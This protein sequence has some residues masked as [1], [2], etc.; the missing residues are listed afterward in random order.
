MAII[1]ENTMVGQK[2]SVANIVTNFA[3][4]VSEQANDI[5]RLTHEKLAS[6]M[7]SPSPETASCEK[8]QAREYPPLFETLRQRL[9]ATEN[10]LLEIKDAISR[11]EL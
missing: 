7:V 11:T 10:S 9:Q 2:E 3:C 6:V 4:K 5:A 1:R 8:E